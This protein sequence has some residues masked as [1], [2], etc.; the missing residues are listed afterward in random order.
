MTSL[1]LVCLC[2][3]VFACWTN[4][5]QGESDAICSHTPKLSSCGLTLSLLVLKYV[6][7]DCWNMYG[8]SVPRNTVSPAFQH[9]ASNHECCS[10]SRLKGLTMQSHQ[11]VRGDGGNVRS[12]ETS[13]SHVSA[14]SAWKRRKYEIWICLRCESLT[15]AL[16]VCWA[17]PLIDC[18][19]LPPLAKARWQ[20]CNPKANMLNYWK[21]ARNS[22]C[23]TSPDEKRGWRDDRALL[24]C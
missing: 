1:F 12:A 6:V 19:P 24:K 14:P 18:T 3:H 7:S 23:V 2:V 17:G 22:C 10:T 8:A 4:K 21:S 16:F 20:G 15:A 5:I 11:T 13:S 9:T